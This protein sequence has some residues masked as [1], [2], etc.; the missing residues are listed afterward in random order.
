MIARALPGFNQIL[1][2]FLSKSPII[3]LP[4]IVRKWNV[5]CVV[6]L[7]DRSWFKLLPT[8][9]LFDRTQEIQIFFS[10]CTGLLILFH[11]LF[12]GNSL[13]VG[14]WN[15]LRGFQIFRNVSVSL[16]YAVCGWWKFSD[17]PRT[18]LKSGWIRVE[19]DAGPTEPWRW[20]LHASI[21]LTIWNWKFW[22]LIRAICESNNGCSISPV[23]YIINL[24]FFLPSMVAAWLTSP[25][26]SPLVD[27]KPL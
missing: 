13:Y 20:F 26:G 18:V 4:L 5:V 12:V 3:Y 27:P 10:D 9:K 14:W 21:R 23:L 24:V 15:F 19:T 2:Q 1:Y 17:N 6:T 8:S 25:T 22:G 16:F 11:E 7:L